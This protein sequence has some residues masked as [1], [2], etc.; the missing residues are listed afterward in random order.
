MKGEKLHEFIPTWDQVLA[1]LTKS[2]DEATLQAFL[3]R[4][5]RQCEAMDQDIAYYD[6]LPPSDSN[7]SHDYLM[8]CARAVTE[9]NR[10]HWYRDELSRSIGGGWV[11]LVGQEK[12][13]GNGKGEPRERTSQKAPVE[14][15]T[16]RTASATK[17]R[18]GTAGNP[19]VAVK[20]ESEISHR[21]GT[22]VVTRRV[23]RRTF[24]ACT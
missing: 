6:R 24:A 4:N 15:E 3:L 20:E 10:L 5:L 12:D 8:K 16:E 17:I 7:K 2:P 14:T 21:H 18:R 13:K 22:P 23:I 1:G 19:K 9:H 11:N